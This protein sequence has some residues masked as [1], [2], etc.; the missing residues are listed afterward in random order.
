MS[1]V[2]SSASLLTFLKAVSIF[3]LLCRICDA[4]P[5]AEL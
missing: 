5:L 3:S 1:I 2:A 4:L